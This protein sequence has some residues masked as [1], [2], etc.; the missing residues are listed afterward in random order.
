MGK[1]RAKAKK[2]TIDF[3]AMKREAS[4]R[5]SEIIQNV[6]SIP[7]Q[8]LTGEHG[9]CPLC[10]GRDRWRVYDNFEETG[11]AICNQCG[12]NLGDGIKVVA[13]QRNCCQLE[14]AIAVATYLGIE[15]QGDRGRG[16]MAADQLQWQEWAEALVA[17][18][19]V[20]K[21]PITVEAV[22]QC[23]GQLA[24]YRGRHSV[25]AFP[26]RGQELTGTDPVGWVLYPTDG[27]VLPVY[28][29]GAVSEVVKVKTL[30]GSR[31]GLIGVIGDGSGI[32]YK[33]EGPTDVMTL[34]SMGLRP[35]ESVV[36]NLHGSG[37]K[38]HK[39]PWLSTFFKGRDVVVVGD[40]DEPGQKGAETWA[41][42]AA[43]TAKGCR[44]IRLPGPVAVHGGKDLRDYFLADHGRADFDELVRDASAVASAADED[45]NEAPDDPHRLARINLQRYNAKTGG[46]V[47]RRWQDS[48]WLWKDLRYSRV[49]EETLEGKINE[50]IKVEF[51]RVNKNETDDFYKRREAGLVGADALPPVCRKVQGVVKYVMKATAGMVMLS[52]QLELDSWIDDDNH[53][54][55]RSYLSVEN[56]LLDIEALMANK[57]RDEVLFPH[58]HKWFS[59]VHLPYPFDPRAD[60][61]R[62]RNF[63][64]TSLEGDYERI[65]VLQEWAGYL[66]LPDT[67]QQRFMVLEGEGAN[68]KSVFCAG[69]E[70]MLTPENCSHLPFERF[71]DPFM[72]VE[73]L[74]KLV[75]I[76]ADV[77]DVDAKAE[78]EIKA[79]T[80]GDTMS[81]DRKYKNA[82]QCTPTA[83]LMIAC[84]NLPRLKDRTQGM[85]R[86]VLLI[87]W[88]RVIPPE[89]RVRGMDHR[90]YWLARGELP[91]ILRWALLG[92]KRLRQQGDFSDCQAMQDAHSRY[93]RD[94]NPARQFL[95]EHLQPDEV[96]K[97]GPAVKTGYLY[98][99]Y[100]MW[101]G[102]NGY[103][104]LS[105][106]QFGKEVRRIFPAAKRAQRREGR[107]QP[108]VY[109]G[110]AYQDGVLD[111][112]ELE[113]AYTNLSG[114]L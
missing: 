54:E 1:R 83:R 81:F 11:G 57:E 51:D 60:C 34:V 2:Q 92:L 48:W 58:S 97:G 67:G 37:E 52:S 79:F 33:V 9:P 64:E 109:V 91:G 87:P 82:I 13:W 8:D 12:P 10:G 114:G 28:R 42:F 44:L 90:S 68:G 95:E 113:K 26:V 110:V 96:R 39:T 29:D 80:A 76:C 65:N 50:A 74:G 93:R 66:L 77:G 21:K 59:T 41:R 86:R 23:G 43:G 89:Q 75:N 100:H 46:R 94:N 38:P 25:I 53:G 6:C 24:T 35:G 56:G 72:K 70:A 98:D 17:V 31:A 7:A 62:W 16:G 45:I 14:A 30:A 49:S 85:W 108:Y 111:D 106:G 103:R 102:D 99:W 22:R 69:M 63:L 5:W 73:T 3:Q 78:G 36:C 4:G 47:I 71:G 61:P 84:N 18:W 105:E 88:L 15:V 40:N 32:T 20:K 19:C 112:H 55:R 27:R 104:H 107:K 101:C